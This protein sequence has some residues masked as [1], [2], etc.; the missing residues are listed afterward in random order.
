MLLI[1]DGEAGGRT[2]RWLLLT[3]YFVAHSC[4][5]VP[6]TCHALGPVTRE[7]QGGGPGAWSVKAVVVVFPGRNQGGRVNRFRIGWFESF[8]GLRAVSGCLILVLGG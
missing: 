8:R 1:Q 4:Q 3:R 5:E 6:P 2:R 7:A